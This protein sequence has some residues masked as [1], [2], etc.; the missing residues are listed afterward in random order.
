M[1]H[2]RAAGVSPTELLTT[3]SCVRAL[4]LSLGWLFLCHGVLAG[5][6]HALGLHGWAQ[7]F[8]V[9]S[10]LVETST[11]P[12]HFGWAMDILSAP[13]LLQVV[14]GALV[15]TSFIVVRNVLGLW[16]LYAAA[17]DVFSRYDEGAART[18]F[19]WPK[20]VRT[21]PES[22]PLLVLLT[23]GDTIALLFL[24]YL[25]ACSC[26]VCC[27]RSSSTVCRSTGAASWWPK[28]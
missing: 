12:L 14:N 3:L 4:L 27:A 24:R 25:R 9:A 17:T 1:R 2:R 18:S 16:F 13:K 6:H 11:A 19:Y 7:F 10:M 22:P 21:A 15:L 8:C 28:D 5:T 20:A 23:R 26:T